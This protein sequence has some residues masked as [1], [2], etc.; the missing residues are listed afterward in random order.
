MT[1][2]V[3][4]FED[5]PQPEVGWI[6][7]QHAEEHLGYLTKNSDKILLSGGLRLAPGEWYCG[8]M[9]VMEVQ[10]RDEA[11]AR[12]ENDP[13]YTLGL[14]RATSCMSGGKLPA[15]RPSSYSDPVHQA[16]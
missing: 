7:K 6:R 10:S 12:C 4:I 13:F 9:W 14:R 11:V 1:R 16:P 5:N 8:G 15:I 3:A 2:W